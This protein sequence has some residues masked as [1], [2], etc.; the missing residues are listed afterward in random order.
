MSTV[1]GGR[2]PG[3]AF[4]LS[5]DDAGKGRFVLVFMALL[6]TVA[7]V[8]PP[9]AAPANPAALIS[10][11]IRELPGAGDGPEE[12]VKQLGGSVTRHLAI[13]DGFVAE[14]PADRIA[15]LESTPG[16]HSVTVD[17]RVRLEGGEG[18]DVTNGGSS[19]SSTSLAA[20]DPATDPGSLYRVAQEV[21]GANAF[22]NAGLT[23]RGVDVALIDSGVVPVDGLTLAG[24]VVNGPDLSFESQASQLRYLDTYGHGTHLAGIIAGQDEGA[25][26][27]DPDA[28]LGVAPGARILSVKVADA[29]GAVDVSQVIAAID[30]V[31]QNRDNGFN[32]RVLA[33]AFGT[34]GNQDYRV[35][36]LAYAV[37]VAWGEG[38]VV[39]VAAGNDGNGAWRLR[40]PAYDPFV[41]AVGAADTKGTRDTSDDAVAAFSACGNDTRHVDVVAPGK[42]LVSLRAG[43]SNADLQHPS[44]RVSDRFFRGSGTSQAAAVV[45][46]A[47]ALLIEQRP[48]ISPDEA[49]ALLM[50]SAAPLV[51]AEARC[52]GA[53]LLDLE[54]A[55]SAPATAATQGWMPST[56]VGSLELARGTFHVIDDGIALTG[57]QDIFLEP[58]D[59]AAWSAASLTG[60]SW[61]DGDWRGRNWTGHVWTG[62][63]WTN[64]SWQTS[65]WKATTWSG[66]EWAENNWNSKSW[67]SKSWSGDGWTGK[68]WSS[69]SW[70]GATWSSSSWGS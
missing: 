32:V 27:G 31:V 13:I 1:L 5:W 64:E 37:E 48:G 10:V 28:F 42:S 35:D 2:S 19:D 17:Y 12:T 56:G 24:K 9:V 57:E 36:P 8:T 14:I 45:A 62:R 52:Q 68:S 20:Y 67:S 3:V 65:N 53:G 66:G 70:S 63:T 26:A 46:G 22:W 69:K 58:W 6:M 16:V 47:A 50:S 4:G 39:V 21:L 7:L 55:F 11:I 61:V 41:I 34:D 51:G 49:K 23:G 29:V 43:G 38:I 33:L 40:N 59:G 15:A 25:V 60:T 54:A 30:W 18:F 44:A